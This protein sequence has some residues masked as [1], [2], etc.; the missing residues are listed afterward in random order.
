MRLTHLAIAAAFVALS[1]CAEGPTSP[2]APLAPAPPAADG[3]LCPGEV[4][5]RCD[6]GGVTLA[7]W[8]FFGPV[9]DI[10][11]EARGDP[12]P[13]A[14]GLWLGAN[15]TPTTCFNDHTR[16]ISDIDKDWLDDNCELELARGFAPRWSMWRV[17][18]CPDGEPAWAAKYF[19]TP[20]VVRIAFMPAYYDDCMGAGHAGDSEF[21]M[22]EVK[23][24]AATQHWE[25]RE[26][27]LSA[28]LEAS[29]LGFG[30]D[31]STWVA[32]ADAQYTTRY[33]AYPA[34]SVSA[35][36]HA[37][38][39]NDSKCNNNYAGLLY[40]PGGDRCYSSALTPF[41]FPIDPARNAGSRFVDR[42]G[43]V[44]SIKRYAG[45]GQTECF[46]QQH[47]GH[48]FRGWQSSGGGETSY[49]FLLN[50]GYFENRGGSFV[51]TAY[52]GGGDWGPG[53]APA[54]VLNVSI[55]GPGYVDSWA[56]YTWTASVEGCN[57]T[58]TFKWRYW[59]HDGW[60]ALGT[61]QSQDLNVGP[62]LGSDFAME[63]AVSTA[64]NE[65]VVRTMWVSNG[66]WSPP[67]MEPCADPS[68][69]VCIF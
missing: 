27:F 53:P 9:N 40:A 12:S 14:P 7:G 31:R 69:I 29:F 36:K 60:Y 49:Y 33:L 65:R 55:N 24:N 30:T 11:Y 45:N 10:L 52:I 68:M 41:R 54:V 17:D 35:G 63:V 15:V 25:L 32:A 4:D 59:S 34:I 48:G 51:G 2:V 18:E 13:G 62:G 8:P 42:M 28:H 64:P 57:P 61:G 6:P 22:E 23:F 46:Y 50:S 37:N 1:G 19:P 43:C 16:T 5:Q 66:T 44:P 26:M 58:C 67:P 20:Q 21:V 47:P 38:Y 39:V 3:T 56:P